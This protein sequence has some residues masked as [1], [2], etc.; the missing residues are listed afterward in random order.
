MRRWG[1]GGE[2]TEPRTQRSKRL[3]AA[4]YSAACAARKEAL[5]NGGSDFLIL[6]RCNGF[7]TSLPPRQG[8]RVDSREPGERMDPNNVPATPSNFVED[9]SPRFSLRRLWQV[10]VF[11]V[12]VVA[13]LAVFLSRGLVTPDP[14]RQLHHD[15][16]EARR[17]L[18]R[19]ANDAN[20][21]LQHAQQAVDHLMYDQGRAAEAFFLLGSAHLRAGDQAGESAAGEH[22]KEARHCLE[23][24]ERRGLS[25][26]DATRL[27]YRMAKIRFHLREDPAQVVEVLKAN[28]DAA[29]DRAEALT[30][31]SQAY[32]RLNPPNLKEALN[33]NKKLRE[34]V[35]RIGEEILGPAKLT[36]AKLLLQLNQRDEARKTLEKISDRAPPAILTEKNMLLAGLYQ[37]EHKWKEAAALWRA[38][39]DEKR[40]PLA[41][42]GSV[43]YNLGVCCRRLDQSGAA[44]EA[45][46]DCLRCSQG[47]EGQAAA[48]AL[49]E[50]H[51]HET[52]PNKAV[53][54][55]AKAV[56]KV[57]KA[58]DWKNSLMDLARVRDLF[59]QAITIYRQAALFDLAVRT[60]E[61][62]ER[63]ADPPKAQV[64]RGELNSDWAK[65]VQERARAAR[66]EAGCKKEEAT[67]DELLRQAAE[68]HTEAAKLF[69]EKKDQGEHLWLS[70]VCSYEGHDYP[71]A[72]DK[73]KEIV[74]R[75]KDNAERM[76]EGLFLLGETCRHLNDG[77][78]AESAYKACIERD[79]RFTYRARYQLAMLEIETGNI[80]MAVKEL[81]QN[82]L[83]EHRDSD[84]EAQEKSRLALCAL[85]YQSAAS[86][87]QYY[88]KVVQHL[89]GHLDHFAVTPESV[90]ARYQLADS[91]RQL[92]AHDTLTRSASNVSEK[93]SPEAF[94]HYLELNKRSWTRAAEEFVKLEELIKDAALAS[95]LSLKQQTEIPFSIAECYFNLGEYEKSLKK[96]EDLAQKW[97]KSQHALRA[98]AFT[99]RCYSAMKDY[100]HLRQRAAEVRDQL[101][102]TEGLNDSDRQRWIEWLNLATKEPTP[103]QNRDSSSDPDKP[104][105]IIKENPDEPKILQERG[106]S[107]DPQRQ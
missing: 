74:E 69:S 7:V 34:E 71:R 59:E 87:P 48:L 94:D 84:P 41:E 62:Y 47:E 82:I 17:L 49:A 5:R 26:E 107:L 38:V 100:E 44:A 55:L 53:P 33:A 20:G 54:L 105:I 102:A 15:L 23:E 51:L 4:A 83:I 73:L 60:A 35:P 57:R 45:W 88:R 39:L 78:A 14:V 97:G 6:T 67:A 28:V 56:A 93:L 106:P 91:Y 86:L 66:D 11:F 101:A 70:A 58:D 95:L 92:V 96:Y 3:L 64:R 1:R 40:V 98:L 76:S 32:L 65:V 63:V 80:D 13:V 30:L 77:K 68:A 43:F 10:P 12:G 18:E 37:E 61:L 31:L 9:N 103:E 24:A 52:H 81:E 19:D 25:G 21:A 46:N 75:E 36:G 8:S 104:R 42:A 79:A 99:I 2:E 16:D 50:L 85:L 29:A 27:G 72:A 22:W 90:R 89:E